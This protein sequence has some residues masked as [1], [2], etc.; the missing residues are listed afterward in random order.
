MML[1]KKTFFILLTGVFISAFLLIPGVSAGKSISYMPN[2]VTAPSL[3]GENYG[4]ASS[5]IIQKSGIP[6][7]FAGSSEILTSLITDAYP[8]QGTTYAYISKEEAIQIAVGTFSD[9]SL[10]SDPSATLTSQRYPL[11]SL[12]RYPSVRADPVW[13]VEVSGVSTDPDAFGSI[14]YRNSRTGELIFVPTHAGGW[15]TIDAITGE[16]I[17]ADRCM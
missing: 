6:S 11:C 16:V 12:H 5:L 15:V 1:N 3:P 17:S 4:L 9:I 2:Q 8:D 7:T 10:T 14:W 13:V